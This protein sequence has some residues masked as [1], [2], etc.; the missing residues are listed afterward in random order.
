MFDRAAAL[1]KLA[2][3]R[4]E[5]VELGRQVE[6]DPPPAG[7]RLGLLCYFYDSVKN[8]DGTVGMIQVCYADD[9]SR[10]RTVDVSLAGKSDRHPGECR[11][12]AA[13]PTSGQSR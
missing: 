13:I 7:G 12:P 11:F 6:A 8:L 3:I 10:P 9:T 4:E 2:A 5:F 1:L